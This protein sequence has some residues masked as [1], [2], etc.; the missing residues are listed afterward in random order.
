M[1]TKAETTQTQ[2]AGVVRPLATTINGRITDECGNGLAKVAVTVRE[3][4][5][6]FADSTRTDENGN[7]SFTGLGGGASY[8]VA[9]EAIETPGRFVPPRVVFVKLPKGNSRE[10]IFYHRPLM[11]T[12]C[13]PPIVYL[14]DLDWQ[15]ASNGHGPVEKD[16]SCGQQQPGDGGTIT[17]NGIT[18]DKGLGAHAHS[19]IVYRL[20]K[21]YSSFVA[22]IGIDDEITGGNGSVVFVV[23]A[24][25]EELYRSDLMTGDSDTQS[26]N[27][28]VTDR[29]ELRL[30]VEAAVGGHYYDHADW[31]EARLVR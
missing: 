31:A 10:A 4:L 2:A 25:G 6:E 8:I 26:I 21:S 16:M 18:Y 30:I 9:P 1:N 19:E 5:G 7:Y 27:V 23:Q 15:S 22:D 28:D 11:P 13:E 17:L 14:S 24:D 29:K 20:D 12:T 3:H